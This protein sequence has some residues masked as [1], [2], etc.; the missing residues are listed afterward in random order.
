MAE[1][2]YN[3]KELAQIL[4]AAASAQAKAL[5]T[6]D[7]E[8]EFSVDEIASMASEV[9]IDSKYV[10]EAAQ[11]FNGKRPTP[12]YLLGASA[13]QAFDRTYAGTLD[14]AGWEDL[15][16]NLRSSFGSGGTVNASG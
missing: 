14:D 5:S 7:A 12:N 6:S 9:G 10:L 3:E 13:T 2:R 8:A 4:R 1:D 16:A 11:Q 15:L